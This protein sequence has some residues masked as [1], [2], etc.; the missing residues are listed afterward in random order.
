MDAFLICYDVSYFVVVSALHI[1]FI[2]RLTGKKQKTRHV[3]A[4]FFILCGLSWVFKNTENLAIGAE[5]L[6]LY[7]M[8]RVAVKN[9]R[10]ASFT[11]AILAVYISQ[12][13]FGMVN[14]AEAI[15]F[16]SFVGKPLLYFWIFLAQ[17]AAFVLC[18]LCY[19]AV[20]RLLKL[21]ENEW[22][23]Y[24]GLLLFPG[25]FFFLVELYILQTSYSHISFV[26][27]PLEL[28]R[29]AAL[30]LLQLLGLGALLCTLYAYRHICRGFLAQAALS[31]LAW[32]A[33]AQR[34]YVEEAQM[35][36]AQ[37]RAFRHDMKN[38]LSI[39]DGLLRN[40]K[41]DESRSYLKKLEAVS[42]SLSFPYR[43]GNPVVDVLL[44]EK[45]G[46]AEKN[47]V[48]AEVSLIL[49]KSCGADDFDLCI[50]F[51]NALDNAIKSCLSVK[52]EKFL[53]I[54]G[55]R[56]GD[57]YMLRFENTCQAGSMPPMGIG[58]SNIRAVAEKYC[59][60]M[61]IEKTDERFCLYVLLNISL[62]V[63]DI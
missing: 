26:H 29:H 24:M 44:G 41:L 22:T 21:Q 13:S 12:L 18:V 28:G 42:K 52:G 32:S 63:K 14:S 35:R 8:S 47:G 39:L 3:F 2:S 10:L 54:V 38:H 7:T 6:A 53:R 1:G 50:I 25:L 19:G 16:P 33:R 34:V 55:E 46:L 58:L 51:A 36:D 40:G 37:T 43:T 23:P 9:R 48:R 20:L 27:S 30:F 56:Q 59:G 17:A 45:L 4:Y 15:F 5:L 61:E 60:T 31:S 62:H 57:F 49:P 11:A